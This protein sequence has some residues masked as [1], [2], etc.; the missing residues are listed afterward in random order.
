MM[1]SSHTITVESVQQ[2]SRRATIAV[3]LMTKNEE[4][5]LA[6]C[7]DRVVGW[8]DEIVIIDDLSTDRTVDVARRYT[9]KIFS[10]ASE[11]DHFQ[12]WNR[13][14]DHATS[15]WILHIDA[16][17]FVTPQLKAVISQM[18]IEAHA[19]SAFEVMRKNVFLG[20]PMQHG[21]WYHRHLI[22]FRRDRAR[23]VGRGIHVRLHVDGTIGFLNADIEHYPFTSLAQFLD[24]QNHYTSVEAQVMRQT[25]G[26]L[27]MRAIIYQAGWRPLKLF[28]KF[29]VK[30]YGHRDGWHGLVFSVLFAFTHMMLWFKYW[31]LTYAGTSANTAATQANA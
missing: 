28:W 11:D 4:I 20:H 5:R 9:E 27:P 15:D 16:D 29:Y 10:Y 8:A 18:L 21:G 24:R 26:Q 31:E 2:S 6:A 23:C 14:I 1:Q 7:L 12:Q 3:V 22:L 19:Y 30:K 17:E 13:G 25:R